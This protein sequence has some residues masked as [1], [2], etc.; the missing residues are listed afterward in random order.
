VKP[1][2]DGDH[3][4][5]IQASFTSGDANLHAMTSSIRALLL[6]LAII[7]AAPTLADG[8]VPALSGCLNES[9]IREEVAA[10]RVVP[11]VAALRAA[12]ASLGGEAVRAR[13]CRHE[14]GMVYAITAL[15]R[16]GKVVRVFVDALS[17]KV[18]G[19]L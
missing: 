1:G 2:A 7:A 11:Q 9:E 18:M 16:D 12:R 10:R 13:L 17:G 4:H 14:G 15:R 8:K 5:A 3:D 6:L 19:S